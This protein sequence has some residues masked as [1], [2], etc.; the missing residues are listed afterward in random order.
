MLASCMTIVTLEPVPERGIVPV[1]RDHREF[2]PDVIAV[3]EPPAKRARINIFVGEDNDDGIGRPG[4]PGVRAFHVQ[5]H[6]F[7]NVPFSPG[8]IGTRADRRLWQH[9]HL[10]LEFVAVIVRECFHGNSLPPH[11][12]EI[13]LSVR[14]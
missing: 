5:D 3:R 10:D 11:G 2:I 13:E 12:N 4:D 9:R 1:R 7:G 6:F 8:V 14:Y